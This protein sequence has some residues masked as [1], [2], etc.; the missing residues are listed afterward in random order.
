MLG[1]FA[2]CPPSPSASGEAKV[3]HSQWLSHSASSRCGWQHSFVQFCPTI[4]TLGATPIETQT[5]GP[6][7]PHGLSISSRRVPCCCVA[8]FLCWQQ[9]WPE[10]GRCQGCTREGKLRRTIDGA[11]STQFSD[12][13]EARAIQHCRSRRT[14]QSSIAA[15][16][17]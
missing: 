9:G 6:R 10:E 7:S 13:N 5:Y 11:I 16:S 17:N 2:G 4:A 3:D 1:V 15:A 8:V 12:L 14:N